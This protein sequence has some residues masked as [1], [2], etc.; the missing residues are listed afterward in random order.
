MP[1]DR[2]IR[3]WSM[4]ALF[5]TALAVSGCSTSIADLPGVGVPGDAPARPKEAGGYLPVHD[6]PPERDEAV[7]K[8]AEQAK[9][10]AELRAA[11]DRQAAAAAANPA[12]K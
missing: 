1:V 5:A 9:I 8:P 11:R 2:M 4:A 6:L 3:L 12:A 10:E 7:I